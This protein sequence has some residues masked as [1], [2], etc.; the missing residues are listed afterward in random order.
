MNHSREAVTAMA[1]APSNIALIKYM[2]KRA[3]QPVNSSLSYTLKHLRTAVVIVNSSGAEDEWRPLDSK[4]YFTGSL[5]W[6]AP[7]L[8]EFSKRRFLNHF[9]FLKTKL[10]LNGYFVI[11]SA[12]NFPADCGIASSASS[13]AALTMATLEIAKKMDPRLDVTWEQAAQLSRQGSGSSIR[14]FYEP[15]ALWNT[16]ACETWHSIFEPFHHQ[17]VLVDGKQKLISSSE[18]HTRVI[19]S[20]LFRGREDRA[21]ERLRLLKGALGT[22]GNWRMAYEIMTAEF[23]DMHTLFHT[24]QPPFRYLTAKTIAVVDIVE[25]FW[26]DAGDGPLVTLDAGPNVHLLYRSTQ[27]DMARAIYKRIQDIQPSSQIVTSGD[28]NG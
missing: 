15:F 3:G 9:H 14:S 21:E 22:Q 24:A 25:E 5:Q 16:N 17:V 12:N 28:A 1:E 13:F 20:L 8:S 27:L 7:N 10:G 26:K 23:W 2:G 18:A 11:Q 6:A 19:T 4:T